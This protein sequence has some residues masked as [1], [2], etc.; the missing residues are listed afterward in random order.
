MAKEPTRA[1][2]RHGHPMSR[3]GTE[4]A[5]LYEQALE[6]LLFFRAD[7]ADTSQ[8]LLAAAPRSVMGHVL[9]AHLGLL[10]TEEKEAADARNAFERFKEHVHRGEMTP[11]ERM[12]VA[13]AASWLRGDLHQAGRVLG[14]ISVEYPRDV[15]ALAV[16]HQIDF[17]TGNAGRLR[18]RI[19]GA[20]SAWDASDPQYGPVLGMYAFG[21]EES[22]H[23]EQARETGLAAV[24]RRPNDVWGIHAVVHTYE[25]QGRFAEGIR[26]LD[27]RTADWATG[28]YLNVH[29]WWHYCLYALEAG[30]SARVLE[31]Y[32][33]ALHHAES[34]GAAMELLD[35]AALLWRLMLAGQDTGGRWGP[36][37]D[38]WAARHDGPYYAFNDVHAVM[39]YVG[40]GRTGD[41]ERI[42]RSREQYVACSG[43]G[44]SNHAMTADIGLPVCRALIAYGEHHYDRAVELLLPVRHRLAEYGGSHAQRDAVHKTLLEAALR[45]GRHDLSRTLL[46]ER[47]NLRPVCPYNWLAQARLA[48]ALGDDARAAVARARADEQSADGAAAL[49]R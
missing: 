15:L 17:F 49:K 25:M 28:N 46:S 6:H 22:G 16:G 4:G 41:A 48:D 39:A 14:E 1:A 47:I 33:A 19:G 35:A 13:A 31:I 7:V 18:D 21:L 20:L 24:E 40:A 10:G 3:T 38:A 34:T 2:D 12:H 27:A 44:V 36:L 29:N 30:D 32:D 43:S 37:A 11:R 23:Y 45:A 9:A 42:V 8:R 26:W 5:A